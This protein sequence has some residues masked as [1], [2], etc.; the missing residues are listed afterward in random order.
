MKAKLLLMFFLV[1]TALGCS[2][3]IVSGSS[4]KKTELGKAIITKYQP[5]YEEEDNY[6]PHDSSTVS[7][8][9]EKPVEIKALKDTI[10]IVN[11]YNSGLDGHRVLI[12]LTSDLKMLDVQ[13]D[14]WNDVEDGSVTKY[15]VEKIILCLNNARFED[16][17]IGYYTLQIRHD[18]KAGS[19]LNSKG[20]QDTTY[21]TILNGKFKHYIKKESEEGAGN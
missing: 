9:L 10:V 4:E 19:L 14:E 11:T 12:R 17:I 13:Y 7:D 5:F 18:F 20:V 16:L 1:I 8:I 15:T 3:K 2:K 6:F 21:H